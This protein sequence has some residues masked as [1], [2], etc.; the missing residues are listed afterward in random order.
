MRMV[1]DKFE[2]DLELFELRHDGARQNIEPQVFDLL[3]CLAQNAGRLV[4]RDEVIQTVWKGRIV[5]DATIDARI[6]SAR[7]AIGD[8]GKKQRFIKTVPRRGFRFVAEV[9]QSN[10]AMP[11]NEP[12]ETAQN[13]AAQTRPTIAVLPFRPLGQSPDIAVLAEAIPH[14]IIQALSRMR[15]LAV[16]ARGS[17][18][19]FRPGGNLDQV[20]S[21]LGAGYVLTGAIEQLGNTVAVIFEL[22]DAVRGE[23]IWGD[24]LTAQADEIE[25][26]R[27]QVVAHVVAALDLYVPQNEARHAIHSGSEMMDAWK[28]FHLGLTQLYNFTPEANQKA[29]GYFERAI[30]LDPRFARAHA[31]LSSTYFIDAFLHLGPDDRD[32]ISAARRHAERGLE[33]DP[34]DPFTHFTMGRSHWLSFEPE[35]AEG[36]IDRAVELNPNYAQGFYASAFT[37]LIVGDIAKVDA[38]LDAAL[39]LSPLDPLLFGIHGVRAMALIQTGDMDAAA[40]VGDRAASTPGAH[41]LISMLAAVANGLAGRNQ[42]AKRWSDDVRKRKPD[43]SAAEYFAAFPTRNEVARGRIAA[44][45]KRQGF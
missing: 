44:E 36:W 22:S 13:T 12:Q 20:G 15:W 24:R 11:A 19:Q 4:S 18:F 31:G 16:I 3:C 38:G 35:I 39:E 8:D 23:V 10:A 33:L 41:Y 40:R 34:M 1:F 37:A 21:S 29:K 43:A 7:R 5:S 28:V 45:L 9:A 27:Q 2:L 25:T 14:E 42:Q 26:M 6:A 17:S 30:F 32:A